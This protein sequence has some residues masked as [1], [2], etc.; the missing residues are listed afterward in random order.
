MNKKVKIVLI[1]LASALAVVIV[2]TVWRL[3]FEFKNSDVKSFI[4]SEAAKSDNPTQVTKII[5]DGVMHIL[6]N[7]YLTKAVTDYCSATGISKEQALVTSAVL[8][9]T[10]KG[11]LNNQ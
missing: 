3:F 5:H 2:A 4:A 6:S 8:D 7:Y 10:N 1:V 11:Y 9:A